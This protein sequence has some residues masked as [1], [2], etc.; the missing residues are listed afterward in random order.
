MVLA[1]TLYKRLANQKQYTT[2][3]HKKVPI[4]QS[5]KHHVNIT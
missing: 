1:R 3:K 4:K 5:P 2:N